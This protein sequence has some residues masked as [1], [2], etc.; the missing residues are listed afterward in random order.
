MEEEQP[1]APTSA[2][3]PSSQLLALINQFDQGTASLWTS[4][5]SKI[6]DVLKGVEG[7]AF[8]LGDFSSNASTA[9]KGNKTKLSVTKGDNNTS[10]DVNFQFGR[11]WNIAGLN[12]PEQAEA[13]V[14]DT[15]HLGLRKEL[16]ALAQDVTDLTDSEM[17]WRRGRFPEKTVVM[18]TEAASKENDVRVANVMKECPAELNRTDWRKWSL[19]AQVYVL[20]NDY[21]DKKAFADIAKEI[22]E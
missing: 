5:K 11:Q 20:G 12:P 10:V 4:I 9:A 19:A 14:E 17:G 1:P 3:D 13:S 21:S 22:K 16:L 8:P 7:A 18:L 2:I 6:E 15:C